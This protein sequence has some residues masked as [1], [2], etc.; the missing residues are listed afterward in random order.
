MDTNLPVSAQ[1]RVVI[2]GCGF[3][4]LKLA[5]ALAAALVEG[6]AEAPGVAEAEFAEAGVTEAGVQEGV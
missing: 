5:Q 4:G 6:T 1:P 3:G 2:V